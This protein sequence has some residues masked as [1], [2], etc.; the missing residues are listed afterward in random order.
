MAKPI[1]HDG[2]LGR[3]IVELLPD[4]LSHE[5]LDEEPAAQHRQVMGPK[6]ERNQQHQATVNLPQP[7]ALQLRI[8]RDNLGS[9][10][11]LGAREEDAQDE[12]VDEACLHRSP[13]KDEQ[14]ELVT[15]VP[16]GTGQ[17]HRLV[18][19]KRLAQCSGDW[20]KRL[21]DVNSDS[22]LESQIFRWGQM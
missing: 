11:V 21:G 7:P 1:V 16:A 22:A 4:E 15:S 17:P 6:Q 8:C 2:G 13:V 3:V 14:T 18:P 12:D 10:Q 19:T 9:Q 5:R 20:V